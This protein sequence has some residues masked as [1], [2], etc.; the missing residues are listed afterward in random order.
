MA[1]LLA[2]DIGGTKCAVGLFEL[3][4]KGFKPHLRN[5]YRCS[6]FGNIEDIITLFF[7]GA[8]HQPDFACIGVAGVVGE[9][10]AR[11][12]NLSW[13]MDVSS[14]KEKFSF[15]DVRLINDMTALCAAV[16]GL[17]AEDL[18]VL[19][20]GVPES[21][22]VI[23]VIAPG[24]GL[25]E[26]FLCEGDRLFLPQGSEGG[27]AR[28][29][30]VNDDQIAL[31]RWL[32]KTH[33]IVSAEMVCAGPAIPTLY[34][35]LQMRGEQETN[36]VKRELIDA[37]DNTAVIV[38]NAFGHSA[39]PLC[40]KTVDLFLSILGTETGNLALKLYATKGIYIGGGIMPRLVGKFPLTSFLN[41]FRQMG[42]MQKIIG[43]IPVKLIMKE[44]I[45]LQGVVRYGRKVFAQ[46]ISV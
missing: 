32:R 46:T 33:D 21:S 29:S 5:S 44:D 1:T 42:T 45:V 40:V 28:F 27:H 30:P 2:I 18:Y 3:N 14:L 17:R 43:A 26:G 15:T 38:N 11:M 23:G 22:G 25:G 20:E 12:T 10:T 39:C 24:T 7:A 31:L 35:F 6:D 4:A 19:Q 8:R 16:P 9:K 37:T 34:K 41:A 13:Q 36:S